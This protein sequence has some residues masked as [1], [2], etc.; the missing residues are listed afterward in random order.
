M[1]VLRGAALNSHEKK[2]QEN[3][4]IF[5]FHHSQTHHCF[6]SLGLM[7]A[8]VALAG[9]SYSSGGGLSEG[10]FFVCLLVISLPTRSLTYIA[11]EDTPKPKR[12]ASS[13]NHHFSGALAVK[14]SGVYGLDPMLNQ[15][16]ANLEFAVVSWVFVFV[17]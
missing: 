4:L 8:A 3:T 16:S 12:K 15:K 6:A 10:F 5:R 9:R 13:S 11:P 17:D 1:L 14:L 2:K 7:V